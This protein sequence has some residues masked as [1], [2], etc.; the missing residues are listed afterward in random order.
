M[1]AVHTDWTAVYEAA[2]ARARTIAPPVRVPTRVLIPTPEMLAAGVRY[3]D[4]EESQIPA[5]ARRLRDT[6]SAVGWSV[7]CTYALAE[8]EI[9][10]RTRE[11]GII[12]TVAVRL[13]WL[14]TVR[15]FGLWR[16]GKFANAMM[17]YNGDLLTLGA[18][19]LAVFVNEA[20]GYPR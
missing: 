8:G 11:I 18:R 1:T 3:V 14:P 13:R 2:R 5:A 17:L 9:N 15:G 19:E 6:A 4:A 16:N 10:M 20:K 12:E 7:R